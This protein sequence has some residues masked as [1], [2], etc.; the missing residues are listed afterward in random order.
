MHARRNSALTAAIS[1]LLVSGASHAQVAPA[2][3]S[4]LE[5]IVVTAT[6]REEKLK[7]VAMGITAVTG[8]D[9]LRR[10][11]TSWA[12]FAAQVPGMS[13]QVA[14][15]AQTRVV[16]RGANVGSVGATVATVVDNAPFSMSGA[17]A[18]GAFFGANIDTFDM[19]RIEVLRG[20]Q[21]T[22]YGATAEGG[23]IRYVTNRPNLARLEGSF[24]GGGQMVDG[25]GETGLVR[26]MINAP[27]WDGKAALRMSGV[28]DDQPGWID[29][30]KLGKE[31]VNSIDKYSLRA[32]LLLQPSEQF[33]GRFTAL[34]Q[35][36]D[37]HGNLQTQV[38]GAAATPKN[39][40]ANMFDQI[41]GDTNAMYT[42]PGTE[43]KLE[44]YALDLDYD[45][46]P[47]TLLST[48]SYG[49]N[50]LFLRTDSTNTNLAPGV[51][52]G[53]YLGAAVY[54]KPIVMTGRQQEYVHKF[55]QEFR[56][57]SKSGASL[58][59]HGFDWQGG[60]FY[61]K[62]DVILS[63]YFD[64]RDQA[65]TDTVLSPALGGAEVPSDFQETSVF[66][67]FT[68]HFTDAF[69]LEFGGRYSDTKQHS[70]VTTFCCV[71]FGGPTKA[72][73]E[74]ESSE[75]KTTWSVAPRFK[76]S[77][78]SMVYARVATG[79]RPGGPNLPTSQLPNPPPLL[80]D[81]TVNYELGFRTELADRTVSID[82]TAF[83][84]DWTDVQILSIVQ[85]PTGPVGINGNSGKAK[86]KGFEWNLAWRPM[87]RL[88][89]GLVGAYTDAT[90]EEDASSLGAKAGDELP[91]VPD[92]ITTLNVDYSWP[93]FSGYTATLGGSWSY[94]GN[95]YTS[96]SSS[97]VLQAHVELPTY[98]TLKAQFGLDNG[99]YSL[100]LYGNN[101]ANERAII[102]YSN[103]G[104][105]NQTG[106]GTFIQPRTW[107]LLVG[108]KF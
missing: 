26:G 47:A 73:P 60:V 68:Y 92:V 28:L 107:G 105:M 36:Q 39:P 42:V 8:D 91:F 46:G 83:M 1:L 45:F 78:G 16:L 85:T 104:G 51:T 89:I 64:A 21:G 95:Q 55:S 96:F 57:T 56:L 102:G 24:S 106:I 98:D 12:D 19:Q 62:E 3:A 41:A 35:K 59:G 84:I 87:D 31:D 70:Q 94:F 4:A 20:P 90:L 22:L 108:V 49:K 27:F 18:N 54:G 63:Q 30:P 66:A 93:A 100:L 99:K 15:P 50:D 97:S 52:Y 75:N 43:S 29:N 5:E 80:P 72:F 74:I 38:V 76:F 86:S 32:S 79:Y 69:D 6:K 37:N 65:N 77:D 40:P 23:L 81:T 53:A 11:E 48:T 61:T 44:Y 9:L 103:Q 58:L 2:G 7:D 25:G 33:S 71:L 13:L 101:L 82:I 34:Y 17:Q 88:T 67:D 14:D 10:Q